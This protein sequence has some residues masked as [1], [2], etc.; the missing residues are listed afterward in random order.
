MAEVAGLVL[1]AIPLLI[2]ALEHSE[3]IARPIDKILRWKKYRDAQILQLNYCSV[4]YDQTLRLLLKNVVDEEELSDMLQDP[5]CGTWGRFGLERDLKA[6]LGMAYDSC[7]STILEMDLVMREIASNFDELGGSSQSICIGTEGWSASSAQYHL[8]N[9]TTSSTIPPLQLGRVKRFDFATRLRYT[10]SHRKI[11][12][13]IEKLK[14]CNER[15]DDFIDKAGKMQDD[16]GPPPPKINFVIPLDEI[17]QNATQIYNTITRSWCAFHNTHSAA[18]RLDSRIR[19]RKKVGKRPVSQSGASEA[20]RFNVSVLDS[21]HLVWL[22]TEF[23]CQNETEA[24]IHPK[25]GPKV[26]FVDTA[27]EDLSL[28]VSRTLVH[29]TDICSAL[30]MNSASAIEF[31]LDNEGSLG[32]HSRSTGQALSHDKRGETLEEL[33]PKRTFR[34]GAVMEVYTLVINLITTLV[35]LGGTPWLRKPWTKKDIMF[36]EIQG[37]APGNL[38]ILHPATS[39]WNDVDRSNI[40]MLGI[41]L[42]EIESAHCL[43]DFRKPEDGPPSLGSNLLVAARVLHQ[44]HHQGVMTDGLARAIEHCLQSSI[45]RMANFNDKTFVDAFIDQTV[46]PLEKEMRCL[47][48]Y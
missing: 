43:E 10:V 7:M 6:K 14:R 18:W 45:D 22:H 42:L 20:G 24:V 2:T 44:R 3:D 16:F 13:S 40:L 48:N 15:L 11:K 37:S 9:N 25:Q 41:M 31:R 39:P 19:R 36:F 17:R 26:M 30:K 32:Y 4:S 21:S 38:D 23:N 1:G 29:V 27:L 33:L 34:I 35:Q 46:G 28:E 8:F 12:E 5:Q 47:M